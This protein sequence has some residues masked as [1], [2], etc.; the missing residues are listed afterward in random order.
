MLGSWF[1]SSLLLLF[2]F[3]FYWLILRLPFQSLSPFT[4][5]LV[6]YSN[7][8]RILSRENVNSIPKPNSWHL[9][10]R[11]QIEW[12]KKTLATLS[13]VSNTRQPPQHINILL[14]R[15]KSCTW[16]SFSFTTTAFIKFQGL[17]QPPFLFLQ[18]TLSSGLP[19][20]LDYYNSFVTNLHLPTFSPLKCVII[21]P[22]DSSPQT[23]VWMMLFLHSTFGGSLL[24]KGEH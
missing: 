23:T 18:T 16:F 21:F 24:S 12:R 19:D 4:K 5:L 3:Y 6:K 13:Q 22:N 7:V 10:C 8:Y 9:Y 20:A 1:L 2:K 15:N 11:E 14:A 17:T